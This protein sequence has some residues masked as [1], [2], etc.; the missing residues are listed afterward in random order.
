M[1][2]RINIE[3]LVRLAF[4]ATLLATTLIL[5]TEES[6]AAVIQ[7]GSVSCPG[8]IDTVLVDDDTGAVLDVVEVQV[9]SGATATCISNPGIPVG[10][11]G[12]GST[13]INQVQGLEVNAFGAGHSII[14]NGNI[15]FVIMEGA[16]ARITNNETG[17]SGIGGQGAVGFVVI[18]NDGQVDNAGTVESSGLEAIGIGIQGDLAR[19]N[20]HRGQFRRNRQQWH[21]RGHRHRGC[22][23]VHRGQRRDHHQQRHGPCHGNRSRGDQHRGRQRHDH[24]YRNRHRHR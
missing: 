22:C 7:R 3:A 6:S 10:M 2:K 5:S 16:G 23:R 8:A 9:P 4:A 17:T 21:G 20:R 13:L 12:T 1:M 24:E 14:N 11:F 19:V 18:G 15:P